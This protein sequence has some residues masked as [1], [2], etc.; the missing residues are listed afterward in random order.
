MSGVSGQIRVK[1]FILSINGD[2]R[3]SSLISALE[4]LSLPFEI[5]KNGNVS[6]AL[7][8][9]KSNGGQSYRR[10]DITNNQRS[11]TFGHRLMYE[12]SKR[13]HGDW[14]YFLFLE[15][16]VVLDIYSTRLLFS[17]KWQFSPPFMLLG[18]CGGWAYRRQKALGKTTSC[19]KVFSDS[20]CG[21]HAY[22]ANRVGVDALLLGTKSLDRLTDA[23]F[24]VPRIPMHVLFPFAAFQEGLS[25]STIPLHSGDG[26]R[27]FFR[28]F[29]SSLYDDFLDL[30]YYSK[31]GI[32][33]LR[34]PE[35]EK[36]FMI[37]LK[38]LPG[39]NYQD[40]HTD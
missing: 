5:V 22:V 7:D 3:S 17:D 34:L 23:F 2:V 25:D 6:D 14:D 10:R 32:R 39:C 12:T 30:F 29:L 21:S 24:R 13:D 40:S 38:R 31:F 36:F 20:I 27:K 28:R 8:F 4:E 9:W 35:L 19:L 26:S 16:D 33:V 11:C 37:F 15:D 18:S 1:A